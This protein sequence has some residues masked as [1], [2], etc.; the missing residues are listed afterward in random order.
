MTIFYFQ[1]A[2]LAQAYDLV[3][4][5]DVFRGR[6]GTENWRLLKYFFNLLAEA[7]TVSPKSFKPFEVISPPIRIMKLYWTKGKRTKLKNICAKIALKCHV[8]QTTAKTDIV[9]FV[10]IIL[11]KQKSSPI[12]SWLKLEPDEV[13]YL[14]KMNKI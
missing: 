9:P 8:S 3:S 13:D 10:N 11:E 6:V 14:T 12:I 4:R 1:L 7:A 5:A 2:D